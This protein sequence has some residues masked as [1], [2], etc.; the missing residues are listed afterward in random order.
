VCVCAYVGDIFGEY[1]TVHIGVDRTGRG[2][3]S[4]S[5]GVCFLWKDPLS[6]VFSSGGVV[7]L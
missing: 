2:T 5:V 6:E 1:S 3:L 4:R 7:V